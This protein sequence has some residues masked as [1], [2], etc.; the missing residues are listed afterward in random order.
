MDSPDYQMHKKWIGILEKNTLSGKDA[1][2]VMEVFEGELRWVKGLDDPWAAY[3]QLMT[4]VFLFN[5]ALA[6]WKPGLPSRVS[7]ETKLKNAINSVLSTVEG[8]AKNLA[9]TCKVSGYSVGVGFPMGISISISF[10]L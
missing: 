3:S 10:A 1:N 7:I 8:I 6:F 5:R 9:K 4:D 2:D